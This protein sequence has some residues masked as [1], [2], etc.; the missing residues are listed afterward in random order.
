VFHLKDYSDKYIVSLTLI[1]ML[2]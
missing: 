1:F 2:N